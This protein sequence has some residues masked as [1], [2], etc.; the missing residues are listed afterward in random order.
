MQ[1]TQENIIPGKSWRREARRSAPTRLAPAI[2]TPAGAATDVRE[3]HA[4][5]KQTHSRNLAWPDRATRR[6]DKTRRQRR[7]GSARSSESRA[8]D[9]EYGADSPAPRFGAT[10]GIQH[11]GT[12]DLQD[13]D[14]ESDSSYNSFNLSLQKKALF[15]DENSTDTALGTDDVTDSTLMKPQSSAWKNEDRD[16]QVAVYRI[17]RSRYEGVD[18]QN[19][20]LSA[21]LITGTNRKMFQRELSKPLFRWM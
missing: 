10:F 9:E 3:R 19:G 11:A 21:R 8:Q 12:G 20:N 4:P 17:Y 2:I 5:S 7:L 14:D 1:S 18:F 13:D 15:G 6:D 16:R